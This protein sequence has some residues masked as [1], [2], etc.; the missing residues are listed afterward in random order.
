MKKTM[1][2]LVSVALVLILAAGGLIWYLISTLSKAGGSAPTKPVEDYLAGQW[3]GYRLEDWDADAG[4]LHLS[5]SLK[6]SYEQLEKY[7]D[8]PEMNDLVQGHLETMNQIAV[9]LIWNCGVEPKQITITG[10]SSDGKSAY[11]VCSDGTITTCWADESTR[12]P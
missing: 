7:G 2:I 8:Q 5:R 1:L 10:L 3:P 12:N 11:T 9:G 4:S 6:L